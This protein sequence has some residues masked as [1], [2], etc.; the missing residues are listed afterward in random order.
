M[1]KKLKKLIRGIFKS[2]GY[3]IYK[4]NT[5]TINYSNSNKFTM[6]AALKRCVN[7]GLK[8]NTV[9]D[10]G[11]SDGRWSKACMD[12][13][14]N[15]DY[16]LVEAQIAH[17]K[18]LEK[19]KNEN[20]NVKYVIAAAGKENGTIFFDNT[21]LFGGIASESKRDKNFVELPMVSLDNE[22]KKQQLKPPYLLK[23]DTH[24]FEIPILEGAKELLKKAELVI[25]ETYNYRLTND[26]LKY[27][28][29][30]HYMEQL[31]FSSI[32]IVDLMLREYDQTFW[33]MDTFFIP[34]TKEE[35][36]YNSYK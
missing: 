33:Q 36:L 1:K 19:L 3:K 20:N 14:P 9:I 23:L 35:F 21:D 24:G 16:L 18:G 31:G 12:S 8:V 27:S 34:N 2:L 4:L 5:S 7:R 25:I 6:Q 22:I 13:I 11:A 10:V 15:A 29:M 30:C 17:K 28:E 26:S 32:E